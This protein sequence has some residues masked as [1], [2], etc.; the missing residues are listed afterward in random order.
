MNEIPLPGEPIP[1][2]RERG[3]LADP[4]KVGRREKLDRLEARQKDDDINF[5]LSTVQGRRFYWDLMGYC[6]MLEEPFTG[7][8]TTFYNCG[9]G[10]VGRKM[11]ADLCR[12]NPA[13]YLQM[14]QEVKYEETKKG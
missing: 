6:G 14:I 13:A 3:D 12:L 1:A 10:S 9:R 4:K 5:V 11:F 2:P 7:N 8:N